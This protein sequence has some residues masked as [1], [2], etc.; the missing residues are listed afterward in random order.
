MTT[1]AD[2]TKR[3]MR[4]ST[5]GVIIVGVL[6][7]ALGVVIALMLMLLRGTGAGDGGSGAA[8]SA[9]PAA[10]ATDEPRASATP[11]PTPTPE[12][13][14][15]AA[16]AAFAMPTCSALAVPDIPDRVAAGEL[17][18]ITTD[19]GQEALAA[20]LPGPAAAAAAL[21]SPQVRSCI[22]GPPNSDGGNLIW[23][24]E[25][26]QASWDAF[27]GQL[28]A[29]GWTATEVDGAAAFTQTIGIDELSGEPAEWWY[30]HTSGAWVA[31]MSSPPEV[32]SAAVAGLR[33]AN[34]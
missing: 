10:S 31:S 22:W 17:V 34:P 15:P 27:A 2:A 18:E 1:E 29:D 16:P 21:E 3:P 30:I 24:A 25:M 7:V 11:T 8:A 12:Q 28:G 5:L 32:R 26:T 33:A 9:T 6:V 23:V 20:M 14:A 19:D 4:R 13:T